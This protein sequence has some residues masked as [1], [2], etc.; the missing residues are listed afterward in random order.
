MYTLKAVRPAIKVDGP[1][2]SEAQVVAAHA[3]GLYPA[4][5]NGRLAATPTK[6]AA[7]A[8]PIWIS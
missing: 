4:R 5:R 1:T 3:R 7:S 6:P 8:M 2:P